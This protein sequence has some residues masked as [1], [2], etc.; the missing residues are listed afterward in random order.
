MILVNFK[1]YKEGTGEKALQLARICAEV[2]RESSVEI[3]PVVQVVDLWR[4]KQELP[5]L[6]VFIQHLDWQPQGQFSGWI[7]LEAVEE[8]GAVGALLNHSEHPIPPGMVRQVLRRCKDTKRQTC[9]PARQGGK[10]KSLHLC[11]SESLNLSCFTAVVCAK[12]L[13]QIE[14][15]IKLKPDLLAYEPPELIG[16]QQASV[17]KVFLK[18]IKKVAGLGK[19]KGVPIIVGAGI[20]SA[21]DVKIS[22]KMGAAGILVS[23]YVVLAKE[24]KR[25]LEELARAFTI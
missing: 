22:L 17:A 25:A 7:N 21:E 15:L 13:G 3:I 11:S 16:S 2:G 23:S 19:Q 14:R 24:Q 1:T 5:K 4:I 12:T 8:A 18:T 9:L 20:H 10:E 6:S